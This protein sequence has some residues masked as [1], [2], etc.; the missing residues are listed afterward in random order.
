VEANFL[1]LFGAARRSRTAD[2]I[3]PSATRDQHLRTSAG[4]GRAHLHGKKQPCVLKVGH[5]ITPDLWYTSEDGRPLEMR[6]EVQEGAESASPRFRPIAEAAIGKALTE[7]PRSK[8]ERRVPGLCSSRSGRTTRRRS[9]RASTSTASAKESIPDFANGD[10]R[11]PEEGRGSASAVAAQ[12]Y[13]A[14]RKDPRF[15]AGACGAR[16]RDVVSS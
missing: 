11:G 15:A 14:R 8:P 5:S 4:Q 6:F 16:G 7:P 2:F 9:R 12:E 10:A 1:P 3:C 13:D